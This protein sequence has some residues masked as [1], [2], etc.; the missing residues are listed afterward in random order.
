MVM[1]VIAIR[2]VEAVVVVVVVL[3]LV[4]VVAVMIGVVVGMRTCPHRDIIKHASD[5]SLRKVLIIPVKSRIFLDHEGTI[6]SNSYVCDVERMREC[7]LLWESL[8]YR[9]HK[10]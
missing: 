5:L 9:I 1:I 6:R 2:V 7:K 3:V 4:V 8:R 10:R